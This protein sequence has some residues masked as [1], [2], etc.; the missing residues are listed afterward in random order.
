MDLSLKIKA[1]F[2]EAARQFKALAD[3]SDNTREKIEKFAEKFE[4]ESI[5]KFIDRQKLA[6]AAITATKGEVA[7]ME[8]QHVAYGRE[9]ERLI[10][11]G[12]SPESEAVKKLAAEQQNLEDKI[13]KANDIQKA[14]ADLMKTAEKATLAVFA[15]IGAG[16]AATGV[17]TQKTAE[18]GD[19]YAKAGRIVGMTAETLQELEHAAKISGVDNLTGSLQKLNKTVADV[20]NGT[21]ALT[22]ALKDTNPQLL[23]QIKNAKSNEEAFNLV[24]GAIKAAPNEFKKAEIA[25]A[26]FG[27]AGQQMILMA[28][29]GVEGIAELREEARKYG[30]ISNEAAKNSE[31]YMDAQ[32]RLKDALKGVQTE[33]TSKLL[34][35]A[36]QAMT[37]IAEFIAS[38]DNWEKIL[39]IAGVS[40]GVVTAA[41]VGFVAVT[42]AQA[43]IKAITSAFNGLNNAMKANIIGAIATVII[44]VLIPA[45]IYLHKNWDTVQT[46]LQQGVARLEYAFKWFGSVI[47]E[48]LQVAFAGIKAAGATLI[49]FIYGNIIRGVGKMLEIMGKLP[50]VGEKFAA[51]S[52]AVSGLGNAMGNMAAEARAAV[53]ETIK[54]AHE[55]QQATEAALKS[56]LAKIDAEAE[57]RRAAIEEKKR[58]ASEEMKVE[59]ETGTA[60]IKMAEEVE[61]KKGKV[62]KERVKTDL[63]LLREKLASTFLV[64]E[65]A[66]KEE[67]DAVS[68]FLQQ[69][70]ALV[71]DD[72]T[73]QLEW[74]QANK[75]EML[76]L[77]EEG[78]S[79]RIAIEAALAAEIENMHKKIADNERKTLEQRLG[80]F[81]QFT[82][83]MGQLL[84]MAA[85]QSVGAAVLSR[86]LASAEAAINSYLAFTKA[87]AEVPTPFNFVA[88]AGVLAAG[89][90]QQ[91]KIHSTPIP[92]AETGG[93]FFVPDLSPRRVDGVGMRV[94]PG[95]E[96]NVTPRGETGGNIFHFVFKINEQTVFDIVNRG[97]RAGELYTLQPAANM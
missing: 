13:K 31:D 46:Y 81:T 48:K 44:S 88:A 2:D 5:D 35:G 95:E 93:R 7:A 52:Q 85:E 59:A 3:E 23:A 60:E 30:I 96:V 53:A 67:V 43:A 76:G 91:V 24:I 16:I 26:A 41:L 49:D 72:L 40:L 64:E 19:Q 56:K 42:K 63:E 79:E 94:N 87:L 77:Y 37:K 55:E 27:K 10:K 89:I 45:L 92:S 51:A 8:A 62:K 20:K 29:G 90:A 4:P 28:E 34:P 14:Q 78:S 36:T 38:I 6:G 12:L 22:T 71:S 54:T 86:A 39:K 11:A 84:D 15:A 25:T 97:A 82:S 61:E 74:I 32:Q 69:R 83:G 57:A 68:Q 66:R 47:S 58:Q 17:M 18:M 21:G 75:E 1:D 80:A 9:I 65:Q 73:K 50:F 33:L 70:A